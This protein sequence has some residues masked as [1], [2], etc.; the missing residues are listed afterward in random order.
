MLGSLNFLGQVSLET[1]H[2][3]YLPDAAVGSPEAWG[4]TK[5]SQRS[6]PGMW[7]GAVAELVGRPFFDDDSR[8]RRL[9]LRRHRGSRLATELNAKDLVA[10]R[11]RPL[12]E[13]W[14]L[15]VN[16]LPSLE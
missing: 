3:V 2:P 12:A 9:E 14:G 8:Y 4:L 15:F 7:L 6:A 1:L 10:S 5:D 16:Q 13:I 11:H